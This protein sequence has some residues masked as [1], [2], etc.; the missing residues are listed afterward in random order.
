M[1]LMLLV[2]A[3]ATP[4]ADIL[5]VTLVGVKNFLFYM[6]APDGDT[7]F[8]TMCNP[9]PEM[10]PSC[11]HWQDGRCLKT[12]MTYACGKGE[13][14]AVTVTGKT[15]YGWDMQVATR[16]KGTMKTR[17]ATDTRPYTLIVQLKDPGTTF[18]WDLELLRER[19]EDWPEILTANGTVAARKPAFLI[20]LKDFRIQLGDWEAP[21]D[22]VLLQFDGTLRLTT[23]IQGCPNGTFLVRTLGPVKLHPEDLS[24]WEGKV[25][26]DGQVFEFRN[27]ELYPEEARETACVLPAWPAP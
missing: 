1:G 12:H 22:F 6:M 27:G 25:V 24:F 20:R 17:P 15:S 8:W 7:R 5:S 9:L 18:E 2:L 13:Q 11:F 23:E 14:V 26:V 10:I 4:E 16:R 21:E 19:S 3:V